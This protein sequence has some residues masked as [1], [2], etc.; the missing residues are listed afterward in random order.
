MSRVFFSK[1]NKII[2]ILLIVCSSVFLIQVANAQVIDSTIL[3][4]QDTSLITVS[5]DTLAPDS[6]SI[7]SPDDFKS[8]VDYNSDDSLLFDVEHEVVY[9]YGNAVVKYEAMILKANYIEVIFN[10][11]I[12]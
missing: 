5:A 11:Y 8:K 4:S 9:L 1:I 3:I 10:I 2:T 6:V 7:S 12:G